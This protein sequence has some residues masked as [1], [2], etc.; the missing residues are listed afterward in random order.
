MIERDDRLFQFFAG[1]FNQDWDIGGA[2]DW[3]GVMDEFLAQNSVSH[4]MRTLGDLRSW[5]SDA[6]RVPELLA[7]LG[8]EYDYGPDGKDGRRWVHA[9]ADYIQRNVER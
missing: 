3:S 9:L 6:K 4:A 5:L 8:C 7:Q 1:Y 2:T